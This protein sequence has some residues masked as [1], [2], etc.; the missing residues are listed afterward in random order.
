MAIE[1]ELKLQMMPQVTHDKRLI[2]KFY[3]QY[4]IWDRWDVAAEQEM[5]D[6]LCDNCTENYLYES[7]VTHLM[8]GAC[9]PLKNR[10][11]NTMHRR[12]AGHEPR[13][14][15]IHT[16]YVV[17]LSR[18]DDLLFRLRWLADLH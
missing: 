15:D 9:F 3:V 2:G 13:E 12:N 14:D 8:G 4:V 5:G 1:M 7:V 11:L 17:R 16:T 18:K 6:W 10:W